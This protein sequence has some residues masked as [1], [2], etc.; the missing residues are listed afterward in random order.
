MLIEYYFGDCVVDS[1]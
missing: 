1:L